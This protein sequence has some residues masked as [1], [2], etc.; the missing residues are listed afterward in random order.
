MAGT[1]ESASPSVPMEILPLCAQR[2]PEG[3]VLW[4]E[5]GMQDGYA[6]ILFQDRSD[7]S[8]MG[9]QNWE[10]WIT[11]KP[12]PLGPEQ[13]AGRQVRKAGK[14]TPGDPGIFPVPSKTMTPTPFYFVS[15]TLAGDSTGFHGF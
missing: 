9:P 14:A 12:S 11:T 8:G 6:L 5:K 3:C 4:G 2:G 7:H 13:P 15:I 10:D 1:L